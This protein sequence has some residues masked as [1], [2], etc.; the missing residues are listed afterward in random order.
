MREPRTKRKVNGSRARPKRARS[1]LVPTPSDQ[2]LELLGRASKRAKERHTPIR[3]SFIGVRQST[4]APGHPAPLARLLRTS[5]GG[6]VRLRFY[7]ALLW[8]AGG[9]DER[10]S[11]TWPAR[12]WAELLD[13]P[14][15][16]HRGDRRI[17]DAIRSLERSGLV[18]T[19]RKPGQPITLTLQ[20]DDG[21]REPYQHPGEAARTTKER[22]EL[23]PKDLYVQLPSEFWTKGWAL[24]LSGPGLAML[25]VM[26]MLTQNGSLTGVWVS[27]QHARAR[28]GI[29]EDT[30]TRG[31]AELQELSVLEIRRRPVSEDFGWRRL[32]NTYKLNIARLSEKP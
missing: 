14:D 22:G 31:V 12:A 6:A 15:P 18:S 20:S 24:V 16:E 5:K 25:L 32:R 10:H 13:L 27:P 28:F 17:R 21:S 11:V 19:Q 7:L 29:S 3:H 4:E 2:S 8:Q 30:W 9:G 1:S 26:L 23:D